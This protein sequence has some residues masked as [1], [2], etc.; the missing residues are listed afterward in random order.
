MKKNNFVGQLLDQYNSPIELEQP[1]IYNGHVNTIKGPVTYTLKKQKRYCCSVWPHWD[2]KIQ[3]RITPP[4]DGFVHGTA[5]Y[6]NYKT[7]AGWSNS[8]YKWEE[9]SRTNSVWRW[10]D[11]TCTTCGK[12]HSSSVTDDWKLEE[13]INPFNTDLL[14]HLKDKL[15]VESEN[16]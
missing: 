10:I 2:P 6:L 16:S 13:F 9:P 15:P 14:H 3:I 8:S 5:Q 7:I 4:G 1:L 12:T 11:G